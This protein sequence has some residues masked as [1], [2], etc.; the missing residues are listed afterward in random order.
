MIKLFPRG[1]SARDRMLLLSLSLFVFFVALSS[2][3]LILGNKVPGGYRV[4]HRLAKILPIPVA[5]VEGRD[6]K[7]SELESA[8]ALG[9]EDPLQFLIEKKVIE[10]LADQ[11]GIEISDQ[12]L[13]G[14]NDAL[15][16]DF[17]IDDRQLHKDIKQLG[18]SENFFDEYVVKSGLLKEQLAIKLNYPSDKVIKVQGELQSNADFQIAAEKFSDDAATRPLGGDIGFIAEHS[19]YSGVWEEAQRIDDGQ[20]TGP[21]NTPEGYVFVQRVEK[22]RAYEQNPERLHLRII[23]IE[24]LD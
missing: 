10:V 13:A 9:L 8:A 17:N 2:S 21:V 15:K 6:I 20:W 1:K 4:W 12:Q 7:Y 11:Q 23:L 22:Q 24:V 14:R 18:I 16:K 3:Y 5:T 19:V